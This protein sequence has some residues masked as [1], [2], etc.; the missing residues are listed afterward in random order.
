MADERQERRERPSEPL[1]GAEVTDLAIEITRAVA[2]NAVQLLRLVGTAAFA[3]A[4]TI[5]DLTLSLTGDPPIPGWDELSVGSIRAR[6]SRLDLAQLRRLR[7]YE[8]L[9]AG[10]PAVITM[11]DNRIAKLQRM[12]STEPKSQGDGEEAPQ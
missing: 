5:S 7:T 8:E 9:H 3:T 11:L 10:R 2:T 4:D 12:P 1:F 6:L